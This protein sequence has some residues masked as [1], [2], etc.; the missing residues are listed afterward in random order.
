M[1]VNNAG[2]LNNNQNQNNNVELNK[3]EKED[4]KDL[5]EKIKKLKND[6]SQAKVI[7][8]LPKNEIQFYLYK[9]N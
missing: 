1:S 5:E 2:E 8:E 4:Q 6:S 7:D 3:K 9:Y